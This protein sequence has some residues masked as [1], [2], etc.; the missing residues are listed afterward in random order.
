VKPIQKERILGLVG[1]R[2]AMSASGHVSSD[3][4]CYRKQF[5]RKG[6]NVRPPIRNKYL[7][8]KPPGRDAATDNQRD[9]RGREFHDCR[10][11]FR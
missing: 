7:V 6:R 4:Q 1:Q 5:K 8:F 10:I 2:S 9:R 11:A 3:N